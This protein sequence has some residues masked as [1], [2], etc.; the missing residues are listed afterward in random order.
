MKRFLSVIFL[1]GV[2]VMLAACAGGAPTVEEPRSSEGND[3]V[4]PVNRVTLIQILKSKGAV[5]EEGDEI[6]QPFFSVPGRILLVNGVAIQ[7][8][9]Y[10][11]EADMLRDSEHVNADG[12]VDNADINWLN[13]RHF[14]RLASLIVLYDGN[15][16]ATLELL[17]DAFGAEFAGN[18]TALSLIRTLVSK[19]ADVVEGEA[20][21][22]P[23][24]PVEGKI[25]KVNGADVQVFEFASNSDME[26]TAA[27]ISADGGSA[28]TT[29]IT[30]VDDPHFFKAGRILAL[31]VG[32]D[33][34]IVKLLE[35]AILPQFAGR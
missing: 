23:F 35:D 11:T 9:E 19:G 18:F 31:Y 20:V 12:S 25:L 4:Y 15:D 5:V 2:A 21:E 17:T 3:T 6:Q 26:Q 7:T 22:Q 34:E 14:F 33:E 24:I 16:E 8:F 29:M 30:W 27:A 13:E 32:S 28:G 10:E 1:A